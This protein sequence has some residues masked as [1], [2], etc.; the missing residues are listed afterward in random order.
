[1]DTVSA[2]LGVRVGCGGLLAGL[3]EL[4]RW[5]GCLRPTM[6]SMRQ[7]AQARSAQSRER[8]AWHPC[9]LLV[10]E[11]HCMW[12]RTATSVAV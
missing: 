7:P 1:M 3:M 10:H 6:P 11:S 4:L 12:H 8:I 9:T 5:Q 2:E